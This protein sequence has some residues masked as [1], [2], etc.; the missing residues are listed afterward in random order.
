MAEENLVWY[1]TRL[2]YWRRERHMTQRELAAKTGI[3]ER[4]IERLD[5]GHARNPNIRHLL[6]IAD[7]LRV[8]VMELVEDDWRRFTAGGS[9]HQ[10]SPQTVCPADS[11]RGLP[12]AHVPLVSLQ[13]SA[14]RANVCSG[15]EI[16]HL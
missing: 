14:A 4:T 9:R 12:A 8:P 16:G 13:M 3:S 1:G 2:S 15:T 5:Q 11:Q 6:A 10:A 7:V